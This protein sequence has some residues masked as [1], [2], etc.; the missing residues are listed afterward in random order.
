M[1]RSR[2]ESTPL[3]RLLE[4]PG[5][6][7]V[8]KGDARQVH[9]TDLQNCVAWNVKPEMWS[10]VKRAID[11]HVRAGYD[12]SMA[13][14]VHK[15]LHPFFEIDI[16]ADKY[17]ITDD[18]L[19]ELAVKIHRVVEKHFTGVPPETVVLK[20]PAKTK[21]GRP[22]RGLHLVVRNKVVSLADM[23]HILTSAAEVGLGADAGLLDTSVVREHSATLRIPH[24]GK[25]VNCSSC[26]H[27][28]L[29]QRHCLTC[30][31]RG[32]V[33]SASTY[34]PTHVICGASDP[35]RCD[36]MTR[37]YITPSGDYVLPSDDFIIPDNFPRYVYKRG[38]KR[39]EPEPTA[40]AV[41]NCPR[42]LETVRAFDEHYRDVNLHPARA[43][44][45]TASTDVYATLSGEGSQWCCT[46][47]GTHKS[48]RIFVKLHIGKNPTL[49]FMCYDEECREKR[50]S[51][52]ARHRI[53]VG[54]E[55]IAA[56]RVAIEGTKPPEDPHKS[57]IQAELMRAMGS[58]ARALLKPQSHD[59]VKK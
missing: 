29:I 34:V 2:W 13:E 44:I 57:H 58:R 36:R 14:I 27:D 6:H 8:N 39:S 25:I 19:L 16:Y 23:R 40:C 5:F 3:A 51:P 20:C 30:E 22:Y 56:V 4:R 37:A 7:R 11:E 54:S 55:L 43:K 33:Y 32:T 28:K 38:Q 10:E 46:M 49:E 9:L 41:F 21:N 35:V 53:A 31:G 18:F 24:A 1:Q 45:T 59:D 17:P 50:K 48:N 15:N 52:E 12:F 42:L 47:G 26:E